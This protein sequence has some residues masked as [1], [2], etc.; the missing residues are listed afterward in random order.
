MTKHSL[1][2]SSFVINAMYTYTFGNTLFLMSVKEGT[3]SFAYKFVEISP[4]RILCGIM[5]LIMTL[6][7]FFGN[8]NLD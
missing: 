1:T 8:N 5:M 7:Y 2:S 4:P 6:R 3:Q